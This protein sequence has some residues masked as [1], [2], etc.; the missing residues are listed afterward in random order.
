MPQGR[1]LLSIWLI[2]VPLV[3]AGCS[4]GG[5]GGGGAGLTSID[6]RVA[7]YDLMGQPALPE[8]IT[9][10]VVGTSTWDTLVNSSTGYYKIENIPAGSYQ[11][12]VKQVESLPPEAIF[13]MSP[14]DGWHIEVQARI[15][16]TRVDL[17]VT[18]MPWT[19]EL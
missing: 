1:K 8:G 4:S 9:V 7:Y 13:L 17:E 18:A 2:C 6:G 3:L 16:M 19:P 12:V 14:P 15:P 10:G 11:V 5:I